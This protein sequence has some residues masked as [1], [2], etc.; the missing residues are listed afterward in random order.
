MEQCWPV[1]VSERFGCPLPLTEVC[2]LPV[3]WAAGLRDQFSS[4]FNCSKPDKLSRLV[5]YFKSVDILTHEKAKAVL[6]PVPP[7]S[8]FFI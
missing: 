7:S 6:S 8:Y 1:F 3:E 5:G 4:N 2:A